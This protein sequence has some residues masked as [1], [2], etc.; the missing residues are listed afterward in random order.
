MLT[1][2]S[3]ALPA[4][5]GGCLRRVTVTP[6]ETS[7]SGRDSPSAARRRQFGQEIG[8]AGAGPGAVHHEF[9]KSADGVAEVL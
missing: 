1:D 9:Q 3:P 2:P 7:R 4:Y 8:D 5:D 6:Q